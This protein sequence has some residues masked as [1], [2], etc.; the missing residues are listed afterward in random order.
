MFLTTEL[1][2][3]ERKM[4]NLAHMPIKGRVAEV[5]M[6]LQNQFGRAPDDFININLSWKV[7]A[8]YAGATY[9]TMFG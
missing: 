2:Q 8:L 9:E 1:K 5:L 4:C 7:L 6:P 3:S